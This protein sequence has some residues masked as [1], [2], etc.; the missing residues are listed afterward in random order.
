V[1]NPGIAIPASTTSTITFTFHQT[2][3]NWDNTEYVLID[4]ANPGCPD[5]V[6]SQHQ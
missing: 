4:L 2:Y 1:P 6:Q 5:L 3:D